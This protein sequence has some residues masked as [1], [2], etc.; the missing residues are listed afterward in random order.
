MASC[1]RRQPKQ[2][3]PIRPRWPLLLAALATA[4]GGN[5]H[6]S[7]SIPTIPDAAKALAQEGDTILAAKVMTTASGAPGFTAVVLRHP[8][9]TDRSSNPCELVI[10]DSKANRAS[11]IAGNSTVV[12]CRYNDHARTAAAM[13]LN[14]NLSV[15]QDRVSFFNESAKGGT[16]FSFALDHQR[17]EWHLDRAESTTVGTDSAGAVAVYKS[18]LTYPK[19]IP[20]LP[21]DDF[22]PKIL[23]KTMADHRK[24]VQ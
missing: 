11:R 9:D 22:D 14:E 13:A 7:A 3:S 10:V 1:A 21:M 18:T 20:W 5:V 15:E 19:Y 17:N 12:D 2:A 16:T 23:R 24:L 4:A 8:L 6:A